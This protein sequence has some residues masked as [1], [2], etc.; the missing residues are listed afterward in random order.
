VVSDSRRPHR[1]LAGFADEGAY[2]LVELVVVLAIL[3]IV[4]IGL[5]TAF[6]AGIRAETGATERATAQENARTALVRMR[7]DIHCA[8]GAP[9]PIE[10]PFG[11]F[12]LTLAESPNV[13][14]SVTTSSSGV[15]WCTVPLNASRW[16]L[17]RFLGTQPEDCGGSADST[18]VVDYVTQP[19]GGWPSNS[20]TSPAPADWNG[21]LWPTVATCPSG[22]M[23]T[24][25]VQF[26]VNV[27]PVNFPNQTYEL[28]DTIALRNAPRCT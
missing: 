4:L 3:G 7:T 10:N 26:A 19:S 27:D 14:P 15:Q 12:T 25:A 21:N 8:S 16:Q 23:P 24:V 2:T 5:L 20:G 9:A 11:G 13:C 6:T 18:L 1:S 28:G 22:N 17:I